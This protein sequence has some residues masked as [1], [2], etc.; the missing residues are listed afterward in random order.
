MVS[1][2]IY[3]TLFC[4]VFYVNSCTVMAAPCT[5]ESQ[6][7][8]Y[9]EDR[10]NAFLKALKYVPGIPLGPG[11]GVLSPR[12]RHAGIVEGNCDPELPAS[13]NAKPNNC[14]RE[15]WTVPAFK[16]QNGI[17]GRSAET[18][19][20]TRSSRSYSNVG[21]VSGRRP[22]ACCVAMLGYTPCVALS[23]CI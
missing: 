20:C 23:R 11:K 10:G 2:A 18:M 4:L 9:S 8:K 19:I 22:L 3:T 1:P 15:A 12:P 5:G 13:D 14:C 16:A 6:C 17:P 7:L 21:V